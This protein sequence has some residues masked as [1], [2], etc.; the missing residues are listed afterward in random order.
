VVVGSDETMRGKVSGSSA[1]P[2]PTPF[3]ESIWDIDG[4]AGAAAG[5]GSLDARATFGVSPRCAG[6]ARARSTHGSVR[7]ARRSSV[8]D[9]T[10]IMPIGAYVTQGT[11][12]TAFPKSSTLQRCIA[13]RSITQ[14]RQPDS[15]SI[16]YRNR[17]SH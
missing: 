3:I 11:V 9:D 1:V 10:S 7:P 16:R 2:N 17:P 14:Q 15:R 4:T 6:P 5:Q 12:A 13:R 8:N